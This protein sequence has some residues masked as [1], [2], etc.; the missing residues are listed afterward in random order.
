M[1]LMQWTK[2]NHNMQR[3]GKTWANFCSKIEKTNGTV[4]WV[5]KDNR[6]ISMSICITFYDKKKSHSLQDVDLHKRSVHNST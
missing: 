5:G 1:E 3:F 2:I 6:K 4:S